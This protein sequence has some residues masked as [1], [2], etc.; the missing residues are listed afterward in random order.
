M[1]LTVKIKLNKSEKVLSLRVNSEIFSASLPKRIINAQVIMTM[2][3]LKA[4]LEVIKEIKF[5]VFHLWN[6]S[7]HFLYLKLLNLKSLFIQLLIKYTKSSSNL[8][9]NSTLKFSLGFQICL[10]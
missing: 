1:L 6:A 10:E 3:L 9:V 8:Q 4:R 2:N 7:G 5:Q